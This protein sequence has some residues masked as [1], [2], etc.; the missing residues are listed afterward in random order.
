MSYWSQYHSGY[1][2]YLSA[3]AAESLALLKQ[4]CSTS[5]LCSSKEQN[6]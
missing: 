6:A 2:P 5:Y 1:E 3:L 4:D